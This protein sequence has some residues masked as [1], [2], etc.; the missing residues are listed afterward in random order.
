MFVVINANKKK[1]TFFY[2]FRSLN[3][4]GS[5]ELVLDSYEWWTSC[6]KAVRELIAGLRLAL[7]KSSTKYTMVLEEQAI[8]CA[9]MC[10]LVAWRL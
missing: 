6:V 8:P 3:C 2:K 1:K 7:N 4:P 5:D 9:A 10:S